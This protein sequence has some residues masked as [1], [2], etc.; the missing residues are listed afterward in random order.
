MSTPDTNTG[1]GYFKATR[2]EDGLDLIKANP[3]ALVL[4][5]VIASRAKWREGFNRQGLGQGEALLGDHESYGMT[6]QQY[7][8]AKSN[9]QE[10]GFATFQPT[11]KGTVGK[12]I[13]TRLF[14]TSIEDS[15][16]QNNQQPTI[17][18][19]SSQ[20]LTKKDPFYKP[21]VEAMKLHAAKIGLPPLEAEKAWHFYESKGW[22]VGN[23]PMKSWQSVLVTWRERWKEKSKP[24]PKPKPATEAEMLLEAMR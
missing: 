5:Y 17:Q 21:S 19:T 10:W 9:L 3:N 22:K 15:N 14:S 16:H 2:G 20:P 13:D 24:T 8:T 1:Q 4:A 12:L 6:R 11:N 7:R 18:P 23:Q